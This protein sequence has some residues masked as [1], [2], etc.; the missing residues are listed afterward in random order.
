MPLVLDSRE[1]RVFIPGLLHY[2]LMRL[3]AFAQDTSS[4]LS[5]SRLD[6]FVASFIRTRA[7]AKAPCGQ[8]LGLFGRDMYDYSVRQAPIGVGDELVIVLIHQPWIFR[9]SLVLKRR[10]LLHALTS[11]RSPVNTEHDAVVVAGTVYALGDWYIC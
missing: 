6:S 7:C 1:A 3:E 2:A 11:E 10:A 8:P 4:A 9:D 5:F